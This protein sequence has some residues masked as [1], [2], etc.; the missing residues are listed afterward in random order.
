M[1]TCTISG[2]DR[3]RL[4]RGWCRAHYERWRRN[5]APTGGSGA[6]GVSAGSPQEF[7]RRALAYDGTECLIW[8]F[9]RTDNGYAQMTWQ[10]HRARVAR[11][12]CEEMHGSPPSPEHQAAH[13]CGNGHMGCIAKRHL[14]WALPV[15]NTADKVTHGTQLRGEQMPSSV[16]TEADVR[17]IRALR[18]AVSQAT[19]AKRYGVHQVTISEVQTRKTWAWLD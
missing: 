5:G 17:A 10:G 16:L 11:L 12:V 1:K 8:P 2:C 19:L 6:K 7:F 14:R 13:N 3:P 15:D 4:A 18:G 9:A